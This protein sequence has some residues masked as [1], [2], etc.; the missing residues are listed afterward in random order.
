VK[1][2]D[3]LPWVRNVVAMKRAAVIRC[4]VTVCDEFAETETEFETADGIEE[5][6]SALARVLSF[7]KS[8]ESVVVEAR[9]IGGD[10][11]ASFAIPEIETEAAQ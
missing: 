5:T 2:R 7:A 8:C 11:I 6:A 4:A 1:R 3:L 10:V 9:S